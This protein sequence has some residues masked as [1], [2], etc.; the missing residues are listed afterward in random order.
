MHK[1]GI[2]GGIGSGKSTVCA[3]FRTLGIAVF[4]ADTE[5]KKLYDENPELKKNVI[6]LFGEEVYTEGLFNRKKM[7]ELV[8]H[9]PE[10]LT[11]LNS[12]IHPLVQTQ[13]QHWM[14]QQQ[15]PYVLKEAALLIESGSYKQLDE[16]VL[17]SCPLE[18]RIERVM[19]RDQV[20]R[21]ETLLRIKRQLPDEEKRIYCQHEII[22][23]GTQLIIPQV[24]ALHSVLLKHS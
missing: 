13:F 20:T 2:T 3:M 15:S 16:L 10:K 8:F 21:E 19:K 17:V 11:Q 12:L 5:A 1:I 22:N 24:L 4:D 14:D 7:A 6:R 18:Q 23:D 9:S